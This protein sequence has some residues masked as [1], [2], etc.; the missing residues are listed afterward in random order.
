VERSGTM[1]VSRNWLRR[2]WLFDR[3]DD[4]TKGLGRQ[5]RGPV[6]APGAWDRKLPPRVAFTTRL[7]RSF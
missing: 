1:G 3:G 5:K 2:I 7:G 6:M 4:Q